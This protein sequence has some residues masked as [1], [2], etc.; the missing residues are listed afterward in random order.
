MP[1]TP[2]LDRMELE[3]SM[4]Y[5]PPALPP[6]ILNVPFKHLQMPSPQIYSGGG[7]DGQKYVSPLSAL[8]NS[9]FSIKPSDRLRGG[10]I[11]RSTYE[12]VSQRY[13]M[14]V[15]GDYDN[16]DAYAQG[17]GWVSKMLSG[18]GKGLVL[19]GTTLIQSTAGLANGIVNM[20]GDG[21]AASFYDNQMNRE[22]DELNKRMEDLLP[23][24]YTNVEKNASWYSSDKLFTANFFWDG[25]IKNL[26]F[27]AG[28]AISGGL[29][30]G[31]LRAL[32]LTSRLF[33]VGKAAETLAATEEGLLAANKVAETYGK[34]KSLSDK[35][36]SS[37]KLLNP[38]GRAVVAGLSTTGEAG[39]EAYHNMHQFRDE[40]IR[41][42]KETHGG[43]E[44]RGA[45]LAAIN[46]AAE[47]V[48][49]KSFLMNTALLSVTNYI[50]FPKILGSSYK[51]ERGMINGLSRE[52]KE[53]VT[54]A[55]GNI[56]QKTPKTFFGKLLSTANKIR[57]YTFSTSE[58][59]EEGAQYAI[60]MGTEDY[61]DKKYRGDVTTN[62][63]ESAVEGVRK[64]LST[65]EGMENVLIGGLSGS[66]MQ[67][68]GTFREQ[69]RMSRDTADAIAKF[70]KFK[71]SDFTKETVDSINRGVV[72]QQERE[73][74]LKSGDILESKDKET[75]Y[76][77]NYLTPRIKYGRMDLIESDIRDLKQLASTDEGFAQLISE[78]RAL[79]GD[80]KEAYLK[81]IISLENT[82]DNVNSLYQS[83]TLR[84]AG[85]LDDKGN[86]LYSQDVID[87]MIYAA[88]K[89]A[90]Y[91]VRIPNISATLIPA[92][93][94]TVSIV[95]EVNKG[96][97]D[98]YD[99]AVEVI[100]AMKDKLTDDQI[101]DYKQ[102][103]QDVAELTLRRKK[104][105]E[106]YNE[107]KKDPKKFKEQ[108]SQGAVPPEDENVPKQFV[109]INTK[110][111]EVSLEIG[112]QLYLGRVTK[113][114]TTGEDFLE[115]P[116]FTILADNGDG[117]IKVQ[118]EN[119]AIKNIKK[120][121]FDPYYVGYVEATSKNKKAKYFIDHR[122]TIFEHKGI[123]DANGKPVRGRLEYSEKEDTLLFKFI[124]KWGKE[125]TIEVK[126][127]QFVAQKGYAK[128][129]IEAVGQLTAAQQTSLEAFSK[130]KD[131]I[132][133]NIE[134]RKQ[135]VIDLVNTSKE[136]LDEVNKELEKS[137]KALAETEEALKNAT[138]TKKG[139]PRKNLKAYKKTIDQLA[140]QKEA[141]QNAINTLNEEKEDLEMQMP[142][143]ESLL[144]YAETMPEN[145]KDAIEDLKDD[146]DDMKEMIENTDA[147][148]KA[149]ESLLSKIDTLLKKALS[150]A[151]EFVQKLQEENP[152]IPIFI[153][154]FRASIE[155]FLGEEGAKDFIEQK[156]GYTQAV[157]DL[158][159]QVAEFA[160]EKNIPNLSKKV[161][162]LQEN[163]N[164]LR[165]G[166]KDLMN[167]QEAKA[168]L[169]Q[170][171]EESVAKLEQKMAEEEKLQQDEAFVRMIFGTADRSQRT[172]ES[173]EA[174]EEDSKKSNKDIPRATI[175]SQ[176]IPG[177]A[178]SVAFGNNLSTL[179]EDERKAVKAILVTRKNQ[180]TI[181]NGALNGLIEH[182]NPE[183]KISEE[184][185]DNTI[186]VVM[187][188][189]ESDGSLRLVGVDTKVIEEEIEETST[190][191][192][193]S[194]P[195]TDVATERKKLEEERDRRIEEEAPIKTLDYPISRVD[196]LM[197]GAVGSPQ[198]V[199]NLVKSD[200]DNVLGR[201]E[202]N[203]M[204]LAEAG[205]LP[206]Y[207]G[208][209]PQEALDKT[210]DL[211]GW[212]MN[213]SRPLT[214]SETIGLSTIFTYTG[215][216]GQS[217][218][219]IE[220]PAKNTKE[221]NDA[222]E[223]LSKNF[224]KDWTEDGGL[225]Y[226]AA[227]RWAQLK[228]AG[229]TTRSLGEYLLDTQ[230]EI[231]DEYQQKIDALEG[232]KPAVSD[233][234]ADIERR[235]KE[236]LDQLS[237]PTINP[238]LE[239]LLIIYNDIAKKIS[240]NEDS[241]EL[242]PYLADL[243]SDVIGFTPTSFTRSK[244]Q[245][246]IQA[247]N[248]EYNSPGRAT[249]M[250]G[251]GQKVWDWTGETL[252]LIAKNWIDAKYDAELAA[253][254]GKPVEK[255]VTVSRKTKVNVL[256]LAIYQVMPR[257]E[258]RWSEEYGGGEMFR[259]GT[260]EG[261]KESLRKQ[262]KEW[263]DGVIA[264]PPT[265][266]F[267]IEASFG[268]PERVPQKDQNGVVITDKG[269]P[270]VN[271]DAVVPVSEAGLV[272]ERNL[273][274]NRVLTIPTTNGI[275]DRGT[276]M[277]KN[278]IGRV[279]L[280]MRNGYVK[281][282]NRQLTDREANTVY[283]AVLRLSEIMF[284]EEGEGIK[285]E[286]A[287]RLFR[288]L[289]SVIYWG[290]PK[291]PNGKEKKGGH[292]SVFFKSVVVPETGRK[293]LRLFI[294]NKGG[295]VP[296]SPSYMRDNKSEMIALFKELYNNVN[297]TRA[298]GG[299][300]NEWN[301]PYEEILEI[302]PN[303]ELVTREWQN[304]Q[305]YLLSA[306]NPDGSARKSEEIPLFTN[307]RPTK[308]PEDP[309]RQ[310]IYFVL[311]DLEYKEPK[312][313]APPAAAPSKPA[314]IIPGAKT[315]PTATIEKIDLSGKVNVTELPDFP[316]KR[317]AW[318]YVPTKTGLDAIIPQKGADTEEVVKII[319]EGLKKA[320]AAKGK[321]LTDEELKQKAVGILKTLISKQIPAGALEDFDET[322]Y[323]IS[324]A[325]VD[326]YD[327]AE[328]FTESNP[329]EPASKTEK[330]EEEVSD[331]EY[332][333]D[334]PF[335]IGEDTSDASIEQQVEEK[336]QDDDDEPL[337]KVIDEDVTERE[338]WPKI[339]QWLK[340]NFPN[341]PVYRVKNILK[342]TNGLQ[343]WG[344]L[345]NGALYV[346]E[347]AEVGTI[348]HEVFEGV[349]KMMSSPKERKAVIKEFT[350]RK[351]TFI[352]RPTG[353]VVAYKDA[354]NAQA[355]E[356][357]AEE[358]RDYVQYKKIPPKPVDGRPFILKLFADIV[359]AV[360]NFF[361]NTP[362]AK[363]NTERLFAKIGTGYY[364]TYIPFE[365]NL[366][367]AKQGIIDIEDAV[368]TGDSE[369]R[370]KM[371][372]ENVHDI[373]QQMT[374]LTLRDIISTKDS[375]FNVEGKNKAELYRMLR[376]NLGRTILSN[377]RKARRA[378]KEGMFTPE[379]VNPIIEKGIAL[380]KT[381]MKNWEDIVK[382]HEEYLKS[383][384]IE[385]DENDE[386]N[387]T[388]DEN[389]GR[390]EYDSADKIDHFRKANS[391]IK[392]LLSTLP[393][394]EDGK[395]QKSS[396]NGVR[397]LPLSQVY[398]ALMN[399]LHT[400]RNLDEMI[401]RV[402]QM[403]IEDENYRT[404]YRRLT[405]TDYTKDTVD[406]SEMMNTHDLDLLIAMWKT[407][408]KQSPDA[409]TI[410]IFDS[411][412]V[413]MGDSNLATAARQL[414][415]EYETAIISKIRGKNPYFE[416]S[417]K[418][419]KFVGKPSG[420]RSVK[421]DSTAAKVEFL[422]DLG[423][424]FTEKEIDKLP[425]DKKTTFNDAVGGIRKSIADAEDIAS[426]SG[427]VLD[428]EGRLLQLGLV[429]AS[430][431]NPEFDST[432]F[433]VKGERT[434]SF[435]GT[436]AISDFFDAISQIKN[437]NDLVGTQYE[438]IL[439][440]E[441]VEGSVI[442]NKMFDVETGERKDS[443]LFM[444]AG[445]ADGTVN[446]ATGKKKPSSKLTY[447]ERFI[448]E[449]N[450]NLN[451]YYSNL[452]PGDSTLEHTVFMGNAVSEQSLLSGF[453]GIFKIFGGYLESEIKLSRN[454]NRTIVQDEKN[455]R[456]LK[457][458]RFFKGILGEELHNKIVKD[459]KTPIEEIY[460]TNE[461]PGKYKKQVDAAV[462]AFI[463]REAEKT[464]AEMFEYGIL[465]MDP[466]GDLVV[467]NIAFNNADGL[468]EP[469][470]NRQLNALAAN[471]IIN[472][473]ELHKLIYS[474][475]YQY[476]DEL[477]RIKNF[478]SPRQAILYGSSKMNEA[479]NIVYNRGYA[480][481]DIGRTDFNRDYFRTVSYKDVLGEHDL[482]G[483]IE[484]M[485][486]ETD[487][488]G[489]IIY[490]AYRNFRMRAGKW[491]AAEETQ[492]KYEIAWEKND[493]G[494]K[495]SDYEKELLADGNPQVR[496]AFTAEKP[497]VAGSKVD[498]NDFNDVV[499]DKYAL[500]PLSY[501]M[502]KQLN[503]T[504]NAL[505]LYEKMQKEDIDYVVF[506]SGRKVG[507]KNSV[508]LYVD[509]KLNPAPYTDS[510]TNIPFAIMS[511]QAEVPSK[512]DEIV[513][514]GSQVTKLATMDFM[515]AGVPIDFEEG[516]SFNERY[517]SWIKLT[518]EEEKEKASPI[519]KEIKNNQMLL[520]AM[521]DDGYRSLLK[522]MGIKE[523]KVSEKEWKYEID[524]FSE[525]AKTLRD[526]IL[527][528][529][530]NDN[531]TEALDDFLNGG[532]VLEA[533]PAYQ[534]IRNILYSIAD[535]EV[536][537]PKL[538]GGMK[539]Q[540]PSTLLESVRAES[541]VIETKK[542]PKTVYTSKELSFYKDEDGKRVCEIMIG[543]WFKSD[544]TDDELMEYFKSDEGRKILS[545]IGFRIPTQKQ[546][547]I[548][549]FVIKRLLPAEF[550]D[551]VIVPAA[552]V[553][554]QGSDFDID[555]LSIYLKN[556]FIGKDGKPKLINFL[557]DENSTAEERYVHWVK[558]NANR[559]TRKYVRFL[560]RNIVQN[561]R[562]NFEIELSKIRAAY[563]TVRAERVEDLFQEMSNEIKS[564]LN[565]ELP[566]QD[567][568]MTEL[569][570]MGKKV[571]WRMS[572]VTREPFWAVR[573][574]IRRR[575]IK[576]PDEIRR[577]LSLTIG[578]LQDPTTLQEDIVRLEGLEKIYTE[579]LRVMGI[580][581][582][583]INE[584]K[585]NALSD[586]RKNKDALKATL[587]L[588]F[589][590]EFDSLN[591]IYEEAKTKQ[592]FEAAEEI[593]N[594]DGLIGFN[595]FK[596]LS[597]YNQNV[598]RALQNG[599]VESLERI[600]THP[601]NFGQLIKPNSA[602]QLK[603][604]SKEIT[605]LR[606]F[607]GFDY[608]STKNMLS[609]TFMTRLR[610]AFVSGKYAIG[611]AAVNQ[612]NHSLNQRQPIYIDFDRID[613]LPADD[614][615]WLGES[616]EIKF[617]K[618]NSMIINGKSVPVLSMMKNQAGEFISD[619]IG[620]FIDGYV[621]IA[622]GPW[623]MEL[624]AAPN[625]A[626]TWLFLIKLGVPM[627]T[628]AYF[629]NQPII[630]DYLNSVENAGYSWLFID[631]FVNATLSEYATTEKA[632]DKIPSEAAL[633]KMIGNK[634]DL[635]KQQLAQQQVILKE[636]LRYA[637]M[638]NHMFL[639]T[640][641]SNFDTA[642]FNDPFLVF[643][644]SEQLKKAQNTII[645][646]VDK[647][648]KN[649]FL[650]KLGDT[651]SRIRNAYAE[652]LH[653]DRGNVRTVLENVLRPYVEMPDR[654]FVKLA[655]KAVVDLFDWAVQTDP[656]KKLN[657]TIA[658]ILIK[659]GGT[660]EELATLFD[661][662]KSNRKHPLRNNYIVQNLI[663]EIT[664]EVN[665]MKLKNRDNK[666]YDQNQVIYGFAELKTYLEGKGQLDLYKRLVGLSVLQSG[667]SSSP[668]S[669]TQL[670]PYEDFKEEYNKILSK[671]DS[672]PNLE[673]FYNLGVFQRNNW[674]NDDVVQYS[675]A[676][677]IQVQGYDGK[678]WKYN[679]AMEF[680]PKNVKAAIANGTI[681][682]VVTLSALSSEGKS[683]YIVYSWEKG[684]EELLTK[685][686]LKLSPGRQYK[687][688]K[689]KK[690]AMKKKGDF[691]Y[692]QK[693]LFQRV[694]ESDDPNSDPLIHTYTNK[695]GEVREYYVY[696]MINAWGDSF[697]ANEFYTVAR[698][699]V[700]D[701]KFLKV[702][703]TSDGPIINAF[704]QEETKKPKTKTGSTVTR[705][706]S[707]APTQAAVSQAVKGNIALNI[708]EDWVQSGQATTT[709]RNSSYHN[710]FYKG[711]G[712]YTTDKGNLVNITY[713]GLVK[714]QG[715]KVVGNNISYTKD[716]FAKAEGFGTWENFKKGAKYAGKTL[717]DGGS[718]HL[719]DIKPAQ[720]PVS[721]V[722]V[723]KVISGGQTG[724]DRIGLEAGKEVGLET[725][726]T[727]TPGFVTESGKDLS[728]KDFG[729]QEISKEL[730]AGKSGKEFYLP[731][732][733][734]NVLN[735]DGTVY[736][737]TDED[738]AG[739]IATERFAKKHN[740][741]FLL[742]PT[743]EQ[744]RN[745]LAFNNIETLNVAGNRGSKLS[746]EKAEEIKNT[747]KQALSQ[748]TQA[749]TTDEATLKS[750]IAALEEKRKTTGIT[751]S[752]IATLM[753]LETK[754]GKIQENKC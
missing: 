647:I 23:N 385:F 384:S 638:A 751:A 413:N 147:A 360:K 702:K 39:F 178:R 576:G 515:E 678:T 649:S 658:N 118:E 685:E 528:R 426:I 467:Q 356:Q 125:R 117:T 422:K 417:E 131:D 85:L 602:E 110:K 722:K 208:N 720:A 196:S 696:K 290:T 95:D 184:E 181:L 282:Q 251:T 698:P 382:K 17:Q 32:P 582:E 348:Y 175:A 472:N 458:L 439:T 265:R 705:T 61:Y 335:S 665:N 296:F 640:Q 395:P 245:F 644:K 380:W 29:F 286:E 393:I 731:R 374:Y 80:T 211:P 289:K 480:K 563:Q 312:P 72:L 5:D 83:L 78:G 358:F 489:I 8:E 222:A 645:S 440:D 327:N 485:Y 38:A 525:A 669:F 269:K 614:K 309:N 153:D 7:G 375:L 667:L 714:L 352:D 411:G 354:T 154:D 664:G 310:G 723:R 315:A 60:S 369:L 128:P 101:S 31:A 288:W 129:M 141:I 504:S 261:V 753:E 451:G 479:M 250:G 115:F 349:W 224:P 322:P 338:N 579:E 121:S 68:R 79:Q 436:N 482:P 481:D 48:G 122:N 50:Q 343:A 736:F 21:R 138:H 584:V 655:Q 694:K 190:T 630:R 163:L 684:F 386:M 89:I 314:K 256:D 554:K 716:E 400:S 443:P 703:E 683:E 506:D 553:Q 260:D 180:G 170:A 304:Y 666:I 699:S 274:N 431:S 624:G 73:A 10:S 342:G 429:R 219:L 491:T 317:I 337:R 367:F 247:N 201:L 390:G 119:G 601:K 240:P 174:F 585:K 215:V 718:V 673:D 313:K 25:I 728:L 450:M 84:Y 30:A 281:L 156:L 671:L 278:A 488:A 442:I 376:Y 42:W 577:Y 741:P 546:N 711:D 226:V 430:I 11:P 28:A 523:T 394:M 456:N 493:K 726:G 99:K 127:T 52:I 87:K 414:K 397:L 535:K 24:Y 362:G 737:S 231:R 9:L 447:K 331:D 326:D 136:R 151:D 340:E 631:S 521:I 51:S 580:M 144:E 483:Y 192:V 618:Y 164:E 14:F 308:G 81:R 589:S 540:I 160:E 18:V 236:E 425:I 364:K 297:S 157:L 596:A 537:S 459:T 681:P 635:T 146:I 513:T 62:F 747:I 26:G 365:T 427:K 420:V 67:A 186:A 345:K 249:D 679:P 244:K 592:G 234:K 558:E 652:Y 689:E 383:Y 126:N 530:T 408:K 663:H 487:G 682:Q 505:K 195:T 165:T 629:M 111:G 742:N 22:L 568:Y 378:R 564:N 277:F 198:R 305:T 205:I 350:S 168:I 583:T 371:P 66:L 605:K 307:I 672:I 619:L 399:N 63:L 687:L 533:T 560:T 542:G 361:A 651:I 688:L 739:R 441:F 321:T 130:D 271:E 197:T 3:K 13:N 628:V 280:T 633:K 145:Y 194:T 210:S 155:R 466:E 69:R 463:K 656:T 591:S 292:N 187:V 419:K 543:R 565:K 490:K 41:E 396:I 218:S 216:P 445:Y 246:R 233:K 590:P 302:K 333:D 514:R 418:E 90:D 273:G 185:M 392:L 517:V 548:D 142:Y 503:P 695:A 611:I 586:F 227:I 182:L 538:T 172:I 401:E 98:S 581:E 214:S 603:D 134:K 204:R 266:T 541:K 377:A 295:N 104:L 404:L 574:D 732:T 368:I 109:K 49:N 40:K 661:A 213:K 241:D 106:E 700:I 727:A 588:E 729:V 47:N 501:R 203:A 508:P 242:L 105:L 680:L 745:W 465:K 613:N 176:N 316:G 252:A 112:K 344:M 475:P 191:T 707:T 410:F 403:A 100:D 412:D 657:T 220:S 752:E 132:R 91:D 248:K 578:M 301:E 566:F 557:T 609:R 152:G 103:L 621:D 276:T 223:Y 606:G 37:Y 704:V 660:A 44:P 150:L 733:E 359:N 643:K 469:N 193:T 519:Y 75:D 668:I 162:D 166:L 572:D 641:G 477:K 97:F 518:S 347:N 229:K 82:I 140:K 550:G 258:L 569:F 120:S 407:F 559:D 708:I 706:I 409:R 6:D 74:S 137:E 239:S 15:P 532:A 287:Q 444:K 199:S 545:G 616:N 748:P 604:I 453:G 346:Y 719:Y 124:N 189:E 709:V 149:G 561:L 339:E 102:S 715:D 438:Y 398:M 524:D 45:D 59:F 531:V 476:A 693:G 713:R 473:I 471:Y 721:S 355:K 460:G 486:K 298:N 389:T 139:L 526:E 617:E 57:P 464:K 177:Y 212:G 692:M 620:Q 4:S 116:I 734:Q 423:I 53:T 370:L 379:Q 284:D 275:I 332:F 133:K 391:A 457:D 454:P 243:L 387:I 701:N 202:E 294:S 743:V 221:Y 108:P 34:V 188:K 725:G 262:Y 468:T 484:A 351:G 232:A 495:L 717:M 279:F 319:S 33:S 334:V 659:D 217:R 639:V 600:V 113:K 267:S 230:K 311:T 255:T 167:K 357:L 272:T 670:L 623:I 299:K 595:D 555:K 690:L 622:K 691:S 12:S 754:L 2:L 470:L 206:I 76:I 507:A 92:G 341:L 64:T 608:S 740:K 200:K 686:E 228:L 324:D 549:A 70:N 724:V 96:N 143:M 283:Q 437:L 107:I 674:N 43:Q 207:S 626:S 114:A 148:I 738:S 71:I 512:E 636:F 462:E 551:T 135:V 65:D 593:A 16:E 421:L 235:K 171:F 510:I 318:G 435:M 54:D 293:Q 615:F 434:Q 749:A 567:S 323:A 93:I 330:E 534:Q 598:K 56:I 573:D 336:Y 161:A 653:S 536:I 539:V 372:G 415:S 637:K 433:N 237:S 303:G 381:T 522:R 571:F 527:K 19:T 173:G 388:A 158:Q 424:N 500:Y 448:Q 88:T 366:S 46:A 455:T 328:T 446:L 35:F 179:S 556:L 36:L 627:N 363:N 291:D 20:I 610:H 744:L 520:E 428:I 607:E 562:S 86:P 169:L 353:Q 634:K 58:A 306:K 625:V 253:L 516:K 648:L 55:A 478:L 329:N 677:W 254:G 552:L 544:M 461:K 492:Y 675:R 325:N 650:K 594:I 159:E 264:D 654:E 402:R 496:S 94:D 712:V 270:V 452:V 285:S 612:T 570:D 511:V 497:I 509:G 432:F 597:I 238:L 300:K 263:R 502:L 320:A 676:R 27:A 662:I 646:S 259:K 183:G 474:D 710:S 268:I 750:Q 406:F 599:Y 494:L 405:G 416:Y 730:Q 77:I 225:A 123:K 498:G 632:S 209:Q 587:K 575:G 449:V 373:M 642:N 697:R 547:S 529:E 257:A 735:S 499:L 1:D 746:K